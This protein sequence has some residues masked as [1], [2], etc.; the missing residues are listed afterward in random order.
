VTSDMFSHLSCSQ[1]IVLCDHSTR[2]CCSG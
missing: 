2:C 1:M